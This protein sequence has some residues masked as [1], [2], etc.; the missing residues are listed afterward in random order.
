MSRCAARVYGMQWARVTSDE[1]ELRFYYCQFGHT[2]L[3]L[4]LDALLRHIPPSRVTSREAY[5]YNWEYG[6]H[7]LPCL[8][9]SGTV[10]CLIPQLRRPQE[11]YD[12]TEGPHVADSPGRCRSRLLERE[13]LSTPATPYC[14]G[15][16][17]VTAR[18]HRQIIHRRSG[19]DLVRSDL[20]TMVH[21]A[22]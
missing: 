15:H 16:K 6:L 9:V 10:T 11:H 17:L 2:K 4:L 3:S 20:A 18:A 5:S 8:L 22:F 12:T 14:Q 1:R 7:E 21:G 13:V 19:L